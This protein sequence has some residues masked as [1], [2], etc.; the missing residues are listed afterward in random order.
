M[1]PKGI[2]ILVVLVGLTVGIAYLLSDKLIERS[3]ESAGESIVGAKVEIDNLNFSLL[4]LSISLERL[5]VANPKD[6]WKNIFETGRMSFDMEFAPLFRKKIIIN[7]VTMAGL[8]IGAKR[9]TDGKI[10]KKST[11]ETPGWADK[12]KANL[13][14]RIASAP[15]LNLAVLKKKINVDSLFAAIDIQ[16]IKQIEQIKLAADSTQKKWQTAIKEVDPKNELVKIEKEINQIKSREI[17]GIDDLVNTL[18]KSKRL[19]DRLSDFKKD[20]DQKKNQSV[21]DFKQFAVMFKSVDNWIE[22]DFNVLKSKA[23]LGEFTSQNIGTMLFGENLVQ[24]ITGILSYID[25]A[26]K[27]MPVAE[28]FASAGKVEKPPRFAGQ[29]IR[30]PLQHPKP[31][32]LME[33]ISLSGATNQADSNDVVSLSG[34]LKGITSHP[35]IYG[36]P[37]TFD[38]A[39]HL[40]RSK[41]YQLSGE[42]DHTKDIPEER[43][44]L[45]ASGIALG[46]IDLPARP[47]LPSKLNVESGDIT[48]KFNLSGEQLDFNIEINA[49]PVNFSFTDSLAK[50]DV[51]S[52]ISTDVFNSIDNLKLS[53]G[54]KGTSEDLSLQI[55]SNIDN[56]LANRINGVIGKSAEVARSELKKKLNSIVGPKKQEA[57]ELVNKYQDQI[58]SEIKKLENGI[59][60][61]LV[62]VEQKKKEIEQ[63]IKEEKGL[64]T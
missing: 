63:K 50:T 41:I 40:P 34:N 4:S 11:D 16:S 47:Y 33:N 49:R 53:A 29:D 45:I 32:F 36:K 19:Y 48:T 27:Y 59:N 1:R 9:E 23:S 57:R 38:L 52:Q 62:I 8:R 26:R 5:Q 6:T 31:N 54:I 17:K 51:I 44:E 35:R 7:D 15:V 24:T 39:A 25:L 42:V 56:I 61:K 46:R 14:K 64:K 60:D 37:L 20:I 3:M 28:K 30:F 18:E 10:L 12:I 43:Y 2:I 55:S 58:N 22:E 21:D 13:K